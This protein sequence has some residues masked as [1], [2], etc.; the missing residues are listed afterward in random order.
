ML[1]MHAGCYSDS[2]F[3]AVQMGQILPRALT[4][5]ILNDDKAERVFCEDLNVRSAS[6]ICSYRY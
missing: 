1:A 5:L 2:R 4:A 6:A 3:W